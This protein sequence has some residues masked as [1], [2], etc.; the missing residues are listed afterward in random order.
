M[1]EIKNV[2]KSFGKIRALTDIDLTIR[3][4][5]IFGMIGS[6]GAGKSTL[7]R[8]LS[9][10]IRPDLGSVHLEAIPIY[11]NPEVKSR[12]FY[13]SDDQFFLGNSTPIDMFNFYAQFYDRMDAEQFRMMMNSFGLDKDRKIKTF[14]KG[15]K[16]QLSMILGLSSDAEYLLCDESFD[17]LDPIA[18]QAI[19]ILFSETMRKR[20]L[21]PI[22]ASHNLRELEDICDHVGLLHK[23]GVIMSRDIGD[24]RLNAKKIQAVFSTP[25][26]AEDMAPFDVVSIDNL[27][28]VYTI[29]VSGKNSDDEMIERLDAKMRSLEPIFYEMLPLNLEEIF[30]TESEVAGYDIRS[31]LLQ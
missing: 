27:G 11:E 16:K 8:I 28:S 12:F 1:I 26:R 15:M 30:I 18:K 19:K 14:S 17:G 10:V 22:I 13:I 20:S 9:G 7:L 29:I 3:N 2:S 5:E 21:T 31:I 23:G 4:N 6:N 24:M 25:I